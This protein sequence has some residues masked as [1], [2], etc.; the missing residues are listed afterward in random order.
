MTAN[1]A[2]IDTLTNISED[3]AK[4]KDHFGLSFKLLRNAIERLETIVTS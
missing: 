4:N 3:F 2:E 1:F